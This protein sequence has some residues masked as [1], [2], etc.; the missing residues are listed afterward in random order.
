MI[1]INESLPVNEQKCCAGSVKKFWYLKIL[2]Y[3]YWMMSTVNQ[4]D[5]TS[6]LNTSNVHFKNAQFTLQIFVETLS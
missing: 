4:K 5:F 3:F 1:V 6:L 2:R